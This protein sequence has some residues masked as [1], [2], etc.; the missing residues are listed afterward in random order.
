MLSTFTISK[1][2]FAIL[3]RNLLS[4]EGRIDQLKDLNFQQ[5]NKE[6]S[7]LQIATMI[8]IPY[9]P[10]NI[11]RISINTSVELTITLDK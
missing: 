10:L 3:Y 11:A 6:K 5:Y 8:Q 9:L 2:H 4:D 7:V 1:L